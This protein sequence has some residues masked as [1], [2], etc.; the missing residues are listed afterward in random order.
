MAAQGAGA[1]P[2]RPWPRRHPLLTIL[3][4][5][6]AILL[7]AAVVLVAYIQI[8][9]TQT[10]ARQRALEA[11]YQF[12][13]SAVP[14]APGTVIR[15]EAVDF[16]PP[17]SAGWRILF[18]S[19][20][21]HGRPSV[22]SGMVFAPDQ[23]APHGGRPV[24][25]WAH[26]T[27][28]MGDACA[29][30]RQKDPLAQLR[31][32]L[33]AALQ[34]GWVVTAPDYAGLGTAGIHEYLVGL[35]EA[36]DVLNSVRAA[37][38]LE[39]A[40]AGTTIAIWGHSQGGQSALFAAALAT[41]YAP[42]LHLMAAGAAAP[43]A[44]LLPLIRQ[45]YDKAVSWAIGSEVA[46]AWPATYPGLPLLDTLSPVALGAYKA[47]ANLCIIDAAIRGAVRADLLGQRFFATDPTSV[48]AWQAP[49]EAN[50]VPPP[51]T[52]VALLIAQG[53]ADQ[54]VLPDTTATLVQ[55]YCGAGAPLTTF[56]DPGA[57][58]GQIATASGP[59]FTGW[60]ADRVAGK[61]QQLSCGQ[62][63]PIQPASA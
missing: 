54:V 63:P 31:P 33:G 34:Q 11:F 45:Q 1:A 59:V 44:E 47:T 3:A 23:P 35:S 52:G 4:A 8:N 49:L 24:L 60:W 36:H 15:A 40:E 57:D 14:G 51:P 12:P 25:G 53:L 39:Q 20:D 48:P 29:P 18:R 30:S 27:V 28:G 43:A 6:L 62:P 9:Q 38:T 7:A 37:R 13:G 26:G 61:P 41:A 19:Q 50:T 21:A 2:R 16:A 55:R 58:H 46:V 22:S 42:E 10:A 32:F 5:L 17:G 56:W